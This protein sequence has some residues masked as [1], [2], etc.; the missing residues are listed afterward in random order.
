MSILDA[1]LEVVLEEQI[2]K[3]ERQ[4]PDS[5]RDVQ[6]LVLKQ[7]T[8]KPRNWLKPMGKAQIPDSEPHEK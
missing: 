5:S 7:K 8:Q 3:M 6:K 1:M 4:R 2:H